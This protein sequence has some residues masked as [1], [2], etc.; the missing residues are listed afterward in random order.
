MQNLQPRIIHTALIAFCRSVC[1]GPD[2]S[3][4][5]YYLKRYVGDEVLIAGRGIVRFGTRFE[6]LASERRDVCRMVQVGDVKTLQMR[7]LVRMD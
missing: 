7:V 2:L 6:G 4:D 1:R 5:A 3:V